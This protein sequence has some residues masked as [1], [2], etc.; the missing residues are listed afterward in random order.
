MSSET[1]R[2]AIIVGNADTWRILVFNRKHVLTGIKAVLD[3]PELEQRAVSP[4]HTLFAPKSGQFKD[5]RR[6]LV[7]ASDTSLTNL[8]DVTPEDVRELP[9]LIAND[10]RKRA[11]G[12]DVLVAAVM[13]AAAA[14]GTSE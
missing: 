5:K 14:S 1:V 9:R 7:R 6:V 4:V 12:G 3:C 13:Q 2:I 10:A 11:Q 8:V